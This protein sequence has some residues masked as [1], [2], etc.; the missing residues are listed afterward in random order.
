MVGIFVYKVHSVLHQKTLLSTHPKPT[1]LR[2]NKGISTAS[3]IQQLHQKKII[4]NPLFFKVYLKLRGLDTQIRQ[5]VYSLPSSLSLIEL[6]HI[7]IQGEEATLQITIPEGRTSWEIFDLLKAHLSLDSTVFDSLV[8]ST[9]FAAKCSVPGHTLEGYLFPDTYTFSYSISEAGILRR[10]TQRAR[11]V[12]HQLTLEYELEH[13]PTYRKYGEQGVFTLASIVEEEAAVSHEKSRIAGVFY[14]RLKKGWPLGAD[15]TVRFLHRK[16]QGPLYVS[17]LKA[18]SPYNTRRYKGLP[19]GPISNPGKES[20]Q[21]ALFPAPTPFLFFV[22]KDDGSR[23][24]YFA[25]TN[26]E[27]NRYKVQ[28]RKN[29]VQ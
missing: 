26:R 21:A 24:H 29:Q 23:E 15:P 13:S 1:L 5:G 22:A 3:L 4:Q 16:L 19:P 20:L 25:K 11:D 14:N 9:S 12:F 2:V 8:H 6:T 18:K 10:L 27:H 17:E 28:R 7:L